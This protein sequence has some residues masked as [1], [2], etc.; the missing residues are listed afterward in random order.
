MGC[1]ARTEFKYFVGETQ[2]AHSIEESDCCCRLCCS[3]L[4]PFTME[5]KELNT[6]AEML[7]VDRP[8]RCGAVCCKCCCYQ[9]M[10]V[11]SGGLLLGTLK[12]ECWYCIPSFIASDSNGNPVYKIHQ[13]TCLGGLCVNC[14][15]EGNPCTRKGCCKVSFR[16]FPASQQDTLGDAPFAGQILKKPKSAMTE[17]F[18]EADAFEVDF[19]EGSAV[20]EKGLIIGSSLL[21]NAVFFEDKNGNNAAL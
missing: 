12:E 19:P 5:V 21:L 10:T 6:D 13:P 7:T 9:Q 20:A 1:E 16:I 18:T 11:K 17:I 2:I 14:C 3:P 8:Y 15:A 4:H